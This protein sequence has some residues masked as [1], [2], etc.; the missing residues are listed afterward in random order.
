MAVRQYKGLE[1]YGLTPA[2]LFFKV[3]FDLKEG[4]LLCHRR[5]GFDHMMLRR[6]I[7]FF[8]KRAKVVDS[9]F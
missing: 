3:A 1:L 6:R 9:L 8:P 5:I 7:R 2:L 4:A